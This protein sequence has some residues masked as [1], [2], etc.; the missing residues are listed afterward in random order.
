MR[1]IEPLFVFLVGAAFHA[2]LSASLESVEKEEKVPK[3]DGLTELQKID[4]V[5]FE[6]AQ[7]TKEVHINVSEELRDDARYLESAKDGS[8]AGHVQDKDTG[9][10]AE[11]AG[12][13]DG[14]AHEECS[15][16]LESGEKEKKVAQYDG[17]TRLQKIDQIEF[18]A[19]QKAKEAQINVTEEHNSE[20]PRYLETLQDGS[21]GHVDEKDD[22]TAEGAGNSDGAAH[23]ESDSSEE[24]DGR[25]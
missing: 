10:I 20:G 6:A 23:E 14:A 16:S 15:E 17:L 22:S 21:E 9:I 24:T 1:F 25:Q 19:A 2:A 12:N 4:Q 11:G 7:K 13:A 3:D 18:E 8:V 5:E